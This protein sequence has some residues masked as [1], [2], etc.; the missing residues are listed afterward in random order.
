[1]ALRTSTQT[2]G[3]V[4]NQALV[5]MGFRLR[6]GSLLDGSDHASTILQVYAQ[7]R[8]EML[9]S[10]DYDFAMRTAPLTLLKSAPAGGYF[11]P[12]AWD[13]TVHP[14]IG[15]NFEYGYP[16]NCLK[17]RN[18]RYSPLWAVNWDPQPNAWTEYNDSYYDV[19]LRTIVTNVPDAIATFTGRVLNPQTWSVTFCDAFA[20]RLSVLLG[21]ALVG[22]DSSRL[23]VPQDNREEAVATT[24]Q[25]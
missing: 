9:A 19:P 11:P 10:F 4:A 17:I 5:R 16:E 20:A 18:V 24:E 15:F 3:D 1:M 13:P 25:R 23:T 8:D 14:P 21:P 6:V 22:L 2:P 7:T 12:N